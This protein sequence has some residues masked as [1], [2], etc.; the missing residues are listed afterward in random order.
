MFIF[1]NGGITLKRKL[2][3]L[4]KEKQELIQKLND[5]KK[6]IYKLHH[7]DRL[8]NLPNRKKLIEIF[9]DSLKKDNESGK[10]VFLLDIDRFHS[11]NEL[12]GRK[13]GD[14]IL[15]QLAKRMQA[16]LGT[17]NTVF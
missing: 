8:T 4:E 16:L 13:I 11:I 7:Y 3:K 17:K 14:K 12:Y 9:N 6:N 5:S 1:V 2:S 15:V 10:A